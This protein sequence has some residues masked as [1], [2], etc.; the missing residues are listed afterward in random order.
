[1]YLKFKKMWN[2][3]KKAQFGFIMSDLKLLSS[4]LYG[5]VNLC[6]IHKILI[7]RTTS[8]SLDTCL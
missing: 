7:E 6:Y 2:I 5:L 1:M 4:L 3:L 8:K